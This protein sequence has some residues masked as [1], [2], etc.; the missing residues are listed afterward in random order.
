MENICYSQ[1]QKHWNGVLILFQVKILEQALGKNKP[2]ELMQTRRSIAH[3]MAYLT[4][5]PVH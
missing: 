2:K 1:S 5:L 4:K 3:P